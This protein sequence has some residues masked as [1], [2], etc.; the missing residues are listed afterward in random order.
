MISQSRI[1]FGQ[2]TL[3]ADSK[4]R[5]VIR[6]L[7]SH[8][9]A[10]KL[11]RIA[12]SLLSLVLII[13]TLSAISIVSSTTASAL[14]DSDCT[15]TV[16]GLTATG[17]AIGN[18]CL[19]TFT[20]GNGT[21]TK[22][23]GVTSV[24]YLLVGGG[25]AGGST[26]YGAAGGGGGGQV[27]DATLAVTSNT[28]IAVVV[29]AGGSPTD[30]AT[31]AS[32]GNGV[33]SSITPNGGVLVSATGGGGGANSRI[34]NASPQGSGSTT[35]WT[36][37]GGSAHSSTT[38]AGSTGTG[39]AGYKGGNAFGSA[40]DGNVQAAGGGGGA[41]GAGVA[42]TSGVPGAGGVGATSN[43]SGT[44][45]YYGG[46][47]GGAKRTDATGT[48]ASGGSGGGGAG[49]I[50]ATNSASGTANTGGGGGG[51]S[52]YAAS[53]AGGS[54]G[55]GVVAFLY[56]ARPVITSLNVTS[57]TT[58][59]GASVTITGLRLTNTT[60]ITIGGSSATSVVVISDTSVAFSTPAG[61]VG[62]KDVVLTTSYGNTTTTG[63]F[64][65]YT[66]LT[67]TC[68]T[69][70]TFTIVNN[71]VTNSAS[72]TGAVAIPEGVTSVADYAF[73]NLN[74]VCTVKSSN[75]TS[76][77]LPST[78]V[79]LGAYAFIKG[80]VT[81][82]SIT[83]PS[84]LTTI[85]AFAFSYSGITTVTIPNSVTS[86]GGGAFY[87]ASNLATVSFQTPSSLTSIG[88][89]AGGNQNGVFLSTRISSLE[90]PSS[91]TTIA[92]KM[93]APLTQL[94]INGNVTTIGA[95]SLPNSLVCLI[96][97]N[98]YAYVNNY[99]Y[100][101]PP[102][103][104]VTSASSC[105]TQPT[106]TSLSPSTGDIAGG[107]S[108]T[109]TGTGLSG[110][111]KVWINSIPATNVTATSATSVTFTSPVSAAVGA[112][113]VW[114]SGSDGPAIKA[115]AFTYTSSVATLSA[116]TLSNSAVLS[117]AFDS[118]TTTYS[119]TVGNSVSSI[120]VTATRTQANATI[121][122]NNV[123]VTS[124]VASTAIPLNV[125][126]NTITVLVTAQNGS[127]TKSYTITVTREAGI[128][129]YSITLAAGTGGTG[130]NQVLTKTNGT[131]LVLPDSPTA[132]SY[133]TRAGY[134]VS[135]WA[136]TDLGVQAYAL[137]GSYSTES[138]TTLYPVWTAKTLTVTYNSKGG[139]T[140][141]STST[142]TGG[143]VSAAPTAPTRGGYSF[144]GW[145]LTDG[146]ASVAF[147]LTH[148]KTADFTLYALWTGNT[149]VLTYEYNSA[150]SDTSTATNS[151]TTG[152]T[153]I[154]LPTPSRTGY[155]FGGWYS[156]AAFANLIGAAGASYSPTGNS[157]TPSAYAK[158]TA[159]N[160]T[161]TYIATTSTGGAVPTDATNYLIGNTVVIKGNTGSLVRSGYSFVGWTYASDG[162]GT[163]LTSGMTYTT[164]TSNMIFYAKWSANTYTVTYNINNGSGN[165]QRSSSNITSDSYT[166]GETAIVLPSLG[167]LARSGYTFGG[168]NTSAAGNG[169]NYLG[170][171][172][173]TTDTDITLYA[174]WTPA[175]YSISYDGNASDGG[176]TPTTGSYTT[177]QTSPYTVLT[178]SF[179]KSSNVFG[180]WNTLSDG[181]GTNYSPGTNITTLSDIVLYAIWIPQYTLHYAVNG[182]TVTSGS[183][184][185]DQLY[186]ANATVGPVFS[187][188]S[189]I[190][191]TFAGW[192]NGATTIP[193]N[194]NFT[195][196]DDSVLT[197][198]W[199]P[200]DYAISYDSNGGS[201]TPDP[202]SKQ[203]GQS[204]TVANAVTKTGYTFTGWL[205]GSTKVGAGAVIVTG[206]SNVTYI[207]QWTANVYTISYDWNGGS[208]STTRNDTFTVGSA[209]V[210]LPTVGDH[211]KDGYSFGG[212]S[213]SINGTQVSDN[214]TPTSDITLYARW[215]T[216]SYV[217][218]YD[219]NGGSVGTASIS[220]L[221]GST[222]TLPTPTRFNFVFDGWF[223]S[224]SGGTLIGAAGASYVPTQ[225]R[226]AYAHWTQESLY[227][228][229]ESAL[230]RIGSAIASS[231]SGTT[232]SH[233]NALSSVT[234]TVP[235]G[236]LPN[237]T[238]INFDLV[239]DYTR[240]QSVLEASKTYI[241]SLVVSWL[242]TS[243][244]V[245][246]TAV[247][248]P[249]S[250][251]VANDTIKTGA[252]VYSILSG[253][254][255]LLGT[256]TQDGTVT[257][258]ITSDPEIV[259]VSSKP[260]SP[261]NVSASSNGA[262]I[263]DVMWTA[264]SDGGS[265]ISSY[266]VTSS[267]G[268][269]CTTATTSCTVRS[270]ASGTS[271]TFTVTARNSN[272][273]SAASAAASARTAGK[274]GAPTSVTASDGGIKESV[275]SWAAP[276]SDG[277]SSILEY[278]ATASNGATCTTSLTSCTLTGL[279][280]GTTYTFSV[281]S[282]N[283]L[284]ISD[285]SS[286]A[287]GTTAGKPSAPSSITATDGGAK[288]SVISW[289][290]P[291]FDGGSAIT[292]YTA[293]ASTGASCTTATTSCTITG[294]AD[295]TTY[296]F[297]VM[298]S[299]A[300]GNSDASASATA[301]TADGSSGSGGGGAPS[302]QST[303]SQTSESNN[304]IT[305]AS[306]TVVGDEQTKIPTIE[307]A[308]SASPNNA[309]S[310]SVKIDT[311]SKKFVANL[312]IV[313]GKLILTP[314]VG[315]SGKKT[316][317]VTIT[318]NGIDRV[319]KIPLIVLPQVVS[320]PVI[321]PTSSSKT[322]IRWTP[323]PNANT[324]NVYLGRK[325][326]AREIPTTS[327][328]VNKILGPN[329]IVEIVANGGDRTSST[330]ISANFNQS[331][332]VQ[333]ASLA[334]SARATAS[335][336]GAETKALDKVTALIS[337]QGFKTVVISNITTS[338]KTEAV[339]NARI[340]A[341]KSYIDTKSAPRKITY[342]VVAPI[343]R[344]FVNNI[345][346]KG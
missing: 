38:V 25:G 49:G 11:Q 235:A 21:W 50:G 79:T 291:A 172:N 148:G 220:I 288:E 244:T 202:I 300:L 142:V 157:L 139:S 111:N 161:V 47:G 112:Y 54:G 315:F 283:A 181:T 96:N 68:G 330:K 325:L 170:A 164:A 159:I 106:I 279:A 307:I 44:S 229:S 251:T 146:G 153:A 194:G 36:G 295:G 94:T 262:G 312:K 42:A 156:D 92:Y 180:G 59:G 188:L 189:R 120:T 73:C 116:L 217:I 219:A 77:S 23:V 162:T 61:T 19:V 334:S 327:F 131:N 34:F 124:G 261:T 193:V 253:V 78:L 117:P 252:S 281:T 166:S 242:T 278:T 163:V 173:F 66:T 33:A 140:V 309:Y 149:Y 297:T 308:N 280:D 22:P 158:W 109:L 292:G 89:V 115:S 243:G 272:G 231:G 260:S 100:S 239:G 108:V 64:T 62:A 248:K 183:L 128:S 326:I 88:A 294:L 238:V 201:S 95:N 247:G 4:V 176:S 237:G 215:G 306:V 32:G 6:V 31:V 232:F 257:F 314:E 43:I 205:N 30:V 145:S 304:V 171:A 155:T 236:S 24:R 126:S 147:P 29:G 175:V 332:T 241:I 154:T 269:T 129:T 113:A 331:A 264:P 317:T 214:Y 52:E 185:L 221:S 75:I 16:S 222:I 90:L 302:A 143:S 275:I 151:Y 254:S 277:G 282:T 225:S 226:T 342:E 341:I 138:A 299:N 207:A 211:T 255:T 192:T 328:S 104:I 204:Y 224:I 35:G 45:I 301:R 7:V 87:S 197:A 303:G 191:Y 2:P 206:S 336:S 17:V 72:C 329:S 69:G 107:T 323:S 119:T 84:R 245:P 60:G 298:A 125:G 270:L 57:G 337:L 103:K 287:T 105:G 265:A 218:S 223:T 40:T 13:S 246:D 118:A 93:E 130:I 296:T 74:L 9:Y 26:L 276:A 335:L 227:G 187:S 182:G 56:D 210:T 135:G 8:V 228:I 318:E 110:V 168:W 91:V 46:G 345:S 76:L 83:S 320:K 230:T 216:G 209:A 274:P 55:S 186:S 144:A 5:A 199:T 338:K 195:I 51:A 121:K 53:K 58:G 179:T 293:T 28:S 10:R 136:A 67:P 27:K 99:A 141:T 86:I 150:T 178:N 167:T 249:I 200:I 133:F 39:G 213:A 263:S 65:Y 267:G 37:G 258:S 122:V 190:G 339:A 98:N 268:Q 310:V 313:E 123:A 316:V 14:S 63:G 285:A 160:R 256:A 343:S 114:V 15:P 71:V 305:L 41:A 20:A 101:N 321:T 85:G 208:G 102:P 319:V 290:I 152:G 322:I 266:T 289:A 198:K 70:G 311:A 212:W 3:G 12:S 18:N 196:V 134:N 174:K 324:Y 81:S 271:Y 203:I 259:I 127:T 233:S 234:V 1:G 132:N 137:G 346:V 177:G 286:T 240:A 340:A 82:L 184:P 333:I 284:G 344:T 250:M 97:P 273:D 169:A 80:G 48:A 165:A